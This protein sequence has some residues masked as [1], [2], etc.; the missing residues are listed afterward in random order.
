M[1]RSIMNEHPTVKL[2]HM[3]QEAAEEL[4]MASVDTQWLRDVCLDAGAD[5]VGFVSIGRTELDAQRQEI[6]SLFPQARTLIS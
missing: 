6:V 5:D 1:A 3:K 2:Y 4:R